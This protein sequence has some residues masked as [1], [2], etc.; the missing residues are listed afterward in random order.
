M[1][2]QRSEVI[3]GCEVLN[4]WASHAAAQRA[5]HDAIAAYVD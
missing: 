1:T 4:H 2:R 3:S 5:A